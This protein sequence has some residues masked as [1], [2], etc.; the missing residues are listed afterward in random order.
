MSASNQ[1]NK[2]GRN[3]FYVVTAIIV[4]AIVFAPLT[5]GITLMIAL[6]T[7]LFFLLFICQGAA[8]ASRQMQSQQ[9]VLSDAMTV[10]ETYEDNPISDGSSFEIAE[11]HYTFPKVCPHCLADLH[12]DKVSWIDS[13][14]ALCPECESLIT[15]GE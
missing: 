8:F 7:L 15:V 14:T 12:L 4:V 3:V 11:D 5:N 9:R 2:R 13:K 1:E 10:A 6:V